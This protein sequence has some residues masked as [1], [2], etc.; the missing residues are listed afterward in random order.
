[1]ASRAVAPLFLALAGAAAVAVTACGFPRPPDVPGDD[2]PG[3][4]EGPGV[5]IHVSPTGD[6]ANDGLTLPVKTLKHAIEI[7]DSH[8]EITTIELSEGRYTAE[9]GEAFPYVVPPALAIVGPATGGA[10]LAGNKTVDGLTIYTGRLTNLELDDFKTALK[11]IGIASLQNVSVKNSTLA[12]RA[13]TTARLTVEKL[14]ITGQIGTSYSDCQNG[15]ILA[16]EAELSVNTLN[17]RNLRT[18]LRAEAASIA[19]IA[20]AEIL[21]ESRCRDVAFYIA[22]TKTFT[23][24]DSSVVGTGAAFAFAGDMASPTR[25]TITNITMRDMG[26][27]FEG[28]SVILR[29]TEGEVSN[30]GNA[31]YAGGGSW[32]F[33][34]VKFLQNGDGGTAIY[35][36]GMRSQAGTFLAAL[37][38]RG[39]SIVSSNGNGIELL[40]DATADLGTAANPGNN[41]FQLNSSVGLSIG[42]VD[43]GRQI[44]AVGNTW[45]ASTQGAG[46]DG[47]YSNVM[48]LS[49]PVQK[50]DGNNYAIESGLSLRR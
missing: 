38:M 23:L 1:M 31:L 32:S 19:D 34:N 4:A 8:H 42:G 11:A 20:N 7:V 25:A 17:V 49:G 39:C 37:S 30:I 35:L 9:T 48:T 22:T 15:I 43:I 36:Q 18:T 29:M 44:D 50:V 3:D 27:G 2:A 24:S 21:G 41:I 46:V 12:L 14:S 26:F 33:V 40:D 6:D 10:V 45:N 47:R 16:G 28:A 13:E 5:T